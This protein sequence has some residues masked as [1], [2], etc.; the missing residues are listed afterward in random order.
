MTENYQRKA[1]PIT[2]AAVAAIATVISSSFT[3]LGFFSDRSENRRIIG[4]LSQI[5]SYLYELDIKVEEIKKQNIEILYKL[6]QLPSIISRLLREES[7][8]EKYSNLDAI[9]NNYFEL[10]GGQR[11]YEIHTNGW[12]TLSAVITFIS[13]NEFRLSKAFDILQSYEFAL[14]T[15][16]RKATPVIN[17]LLT[18]KISDYLI[19][20]NELYQPVLSSFYKLLELFNNKEYVKSHNFNEDLSDLQLLEFK[21]VEDLSE[22]ETYTYVTYRS[23]G[24]QEPRIREVNQGNRPSEIGI[25]FNTNKKRHFNTINEE[26]ILYKKR[27]QNYKEIID[28]IKAFQNYLM[29]I[30]NDYV[31]SKL[32]D[33]DTKDLDNFF[34]EIN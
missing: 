9:R 18:D 28:L 32:A 20:K 15:T 17:S 21:K 13:Q 24:Y 34:I 33:S 6:D 23:G 25:E 16:R 27:L 12:Q 26:L 10:Q 4:L 2:I 3:V 1:E 7:L 14:C 29:I 31:K 8:N 19:I 30:N 5:K 11:Q 22:T